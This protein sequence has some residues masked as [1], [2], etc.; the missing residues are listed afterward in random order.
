MRR[1]VFIALAALAVFSS[2]GLDMPGMP[3][4]RGE[5]VITVAD[6]SGLLP[7]SVAGVPFYLD[8][9]EVSIDSRTNVFT[10]MATTNAA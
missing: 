2:C 1:G 7:G 4:G 5:F 10:A 3:D 8:S 9:T 6:T